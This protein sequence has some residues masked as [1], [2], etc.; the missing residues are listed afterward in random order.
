MIDY[1]GAIECRV[2]A[3]GTRL[4][5]VAMRYGSVGRGPVPEVFLPGSLVPTANVHLNREHNPKDVLASM[6]RG[7]LTLSM[8]A[9]ELRV[10]AVLNPPIN[11]G[12]IGLSVEFVAKESV[13]VHGVREIRRAVLH[14]IGATA[15]PAYPQSQAEVRRR[16][17]GGSFSY[18]QLKTVSD[19]ATKRRKQRIHPGAFNY[20]FEDGGRRLVQELTV[21]LRLGHR[22]T[23]ANVLADTKAGTLTLEDGKDALKFSVASL[24]ATSA[25]KDARALE[26]AGQ[27][28]VDAIISIPPDVDGAVELV[29]E[30]GNP[31]VSVEEVRS[32]VLRSLV[33]TPRTPAGLEPTLRTR[34]VGGVRRTWQS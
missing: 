26:K 9:I 5:G 10:D 22:A 23:G 34:Y 19:R 4:S 24:P 14:G 13:M 25:A 27:L 21:D 20:Q 2:D 17:F 6:E 11:P 18:G 28:G 12:P 7:T 15:R 32:A 8:S 29:P 1:A 16:S 30:P 33:L 31:S 3:P